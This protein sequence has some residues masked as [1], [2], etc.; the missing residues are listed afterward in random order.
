MISD[1]FDETT[2]LRTAKDSAGL[3]PLPNV[4]VRETDS[5]PS[6]GA[7]PWLTSAWLARRLARLCGSSSSTEIEC[8]DALAVSLLQ[9]TANPQLREAAAHTGLGYQNGTWAMSPS[10]EW[11]YPGG[12]P[13]WSDRGDLRYP[14]GTCAHWKEA[15]IFNFPHG[16]PAAQGQILF[17]ADQRPLT[18][19]QLEHE[20]RDAT[21]L[22]PRYER[23]LAELEG[24][25]LAKG[26]ALVE[27]A[28]LYLRP[29]TSTPAREAES[30]A[31]AVF[32]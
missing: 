24:N 9:I 3:P 31:T 12:M 17:T 2:C 30:D 4:I 19:A 22:W 29:W 20:L 5:V 25:E 28:W 14:D 16:M 15:G 6:P 26:L 18:V 10:G 21:E 1:A 27:L 7:D 11:T 32:Q 23:G 13:L 8:L